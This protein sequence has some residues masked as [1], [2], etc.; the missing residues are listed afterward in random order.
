MTTQPF[1]TVIVPTTHERKHWNEQ[2]LNQYIAQDY[3]PKEI[4][5]DYNHGT[6]GEKRNRLCN[7]SK[8]DII[9]HFDSDDAYASDWITKSVADLIES[10]AD[11]AGLSN[12]NFYD[13]IK[14]EA[15]GYDYYKG[16]N[17]WHY[18][19][20]WV[21]GATMCYWK[22]FW[23]RHPFKDVQVGEDGAFVTA[24]SGETIRIA[25]HDYVD[26]FLASIHPG[27]T[28]G[29]QLYSNPRYTR[30]SEEEKERIKRRFFGAG[31]NATI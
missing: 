22:K 8:G 28:S 31:A 29:R 19:Q 6:I 30:L 13:Y 20:A 24:N 26:G 15:W 1:I 25:S 2:I 18:E 14:D 9:F 17:K 27:N 23:E 21:C 12:V 4:L 16:Q 7:I 3:H 10:K 5:F 11:I